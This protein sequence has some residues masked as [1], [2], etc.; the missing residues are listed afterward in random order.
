MFGIYL[1]T[2]ATKR[3][4]VS[5]IILKRRFPGS[6]LHYHAAPRRACFL[7]HHAKAPMKMN[8][9]DKFFIFFI[10]SF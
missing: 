6:P 5:N 3:K 7:I 2:I 4:T 1:Q 8:F 10:N 9:V